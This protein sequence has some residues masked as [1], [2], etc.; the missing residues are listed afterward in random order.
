[1]SLPLACPSV[2]STPLKTTLEVLTGKYLSSCNSQGTLQRQLEFKGRILPFAWVPVPLALPT[3]LIAA[4]GALKVGVP[5]LQRCHP[6][7]V[8]L[9]ALHQAPIPAPHMQS[10]LHGQNASSS[11][12]PSLLSMLLI[13]EV[14]DVLHSLCYILQMHLCFQ[15]RMSDKSHL[16]VH[17]R[18]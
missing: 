1:M 12:M 9:R 10:L 14:T 17:P 11:V 16:A 5:F 8:W 6:L 7:T 2:L 4:L 3:P 15:A 13:R 18:L